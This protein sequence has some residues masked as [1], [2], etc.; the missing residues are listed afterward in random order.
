MRR[1]AIEDGHEATTKYHPHIHDNELTCALHTDETE[2]IM[3]PTA[4][5]KAFRQFTRSR[6]KQAESSN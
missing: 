3:N 2:Y 1:L 5:K 6:A 4:D